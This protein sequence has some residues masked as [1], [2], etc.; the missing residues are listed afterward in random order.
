M[1]HQQEEVRFTSSH[2][3]PFKGVLWFCFG[4]LCFACMTTIVRHLA[5]GGIHPFVMILFRNV[6]GL[7]I[8]TPWIIKHKQAIVNT[9]K[10]KLHIWRGVNGFVGMVLFFYGLSLLPVTEAIALS[11]TVPLFTTIAA[12]VWLKEIVDRPRWIALIIG[13]VG[14][15]VILRPGFDTF[16]SA[17]FYVIGA[18]CSWSI[19]NIIIKKLTRTEH[20]TVVVFYMTSIMIPLSLVLAIPV[21]DMPSTEQLIWLLALGCTSVLA[22]YSITHAYGFSDVSF[23]QPFDFS[24]LIFVSI[25]AF[26]AFQEI[27]DIVTLIGAIVIFASSVYITKYERK[28]VITETYES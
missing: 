16:N 17:A 1:S 6:L 9:T 23:L 5:D 19:S 25:I 24:R 4:A 28:K 26:F 3:A 2:S 10:I 21:F 20:P 13:F 7:T 27:I 8:L 12:I 11:Y 15:L 18:T 22:Q 14:V